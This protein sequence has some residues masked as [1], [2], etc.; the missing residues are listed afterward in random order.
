MKA[1]IP[2]LV[3]IL[4]SHHLYICTPFTWTPYLVLKV[5]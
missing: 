1:K 3:S 5:G 2:I 4:F